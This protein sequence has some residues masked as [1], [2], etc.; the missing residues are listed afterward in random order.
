[1]KNYGLFGSKI[2][3]WI[4]SVGNAK[5]ELTKLNFITSC[6]L[7]LNRQTGLYSNFSNDI[8]NNPIN[9][10]F[11]SHSKITIQANGLNYIEIKKTKHFGE[12]LII[13]SNNKILNLFFFNTINKAEF[14]KD[15]EK[16]LQKNFINTGE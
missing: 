5:V 10:H 4:I 9:N 8:L 14:Y 11:R 1:M 12:K 3:L 16:C 13:K 2:Y 15:L 7:E 6:K